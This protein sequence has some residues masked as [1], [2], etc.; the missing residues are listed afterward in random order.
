MSFRAG[1]L[2]LLVTVAAVCRAQD[3]DGPATAAL[4][5]APGATA[6]VIFPNVP[7]GQPLSVWSTFRADATPVNSSGGAARVRLTLPATSPVGVGAV[8]IAT[9]GGVSDLQLFIRD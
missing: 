9:T 7:A 4:F 8:R 2:V 1:L 3:D 5:A 6:D